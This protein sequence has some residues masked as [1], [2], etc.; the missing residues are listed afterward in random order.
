MKDDAEL[1]AGNGTN[2]SLRLHL[3][4]DGLQDLQRPLKRS[5]PV[6]Q[7]LGVCRYNVNQ[8]WNVLRVVLAVQL[9]QI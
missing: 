8:R 7:R 9:G 4:H 6:P 1:L 5:H 3:H 2:A